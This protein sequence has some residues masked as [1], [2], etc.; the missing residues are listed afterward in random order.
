MEPAVGR[1]DRVFSVTDSAAAV[2]IGPVAKPAAADPRI[3]RVIALMDRAP[4]RRLPLWELAGTAGLSLSRLSHLF[5]SEVGMS[6]GRYLKAA[7]LA[8]AKALL[9]TSSF[10]VKEV[11]AQTGFS[12]VGRFIADFRKAYSLT[13]YQHRRARAPRAMGNPHNG[14]C[15]SRRD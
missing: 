10:R 1:E 12:H 5:R 7:R 6:P 14:S 2:G 13:P 11:A 15:N 3:G 9:E 8:R 4:L